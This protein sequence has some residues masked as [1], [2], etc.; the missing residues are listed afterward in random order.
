YQ[1]LAFQGEDEANRL[2]VTFDRDLRLVNTSNMNAPDNYEKIFLPPNR[3]VLEVKV[4]EYIPRWMLKFFQR[5]ELMQQ[6]YSKYCSAM[7]T[8]Y[9]QDV[10]RA[11]W[12]P[13]TQD[14]DGLLAG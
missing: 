2:R 6:R 1:R 8:E 5:H 4:S 13:R 11:V 9:G 3:M 12:T 10:S 7:A 14:T